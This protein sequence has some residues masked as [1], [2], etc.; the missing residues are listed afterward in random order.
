MKPALLLTALFGL[1]EAAANAKVGRVEILERAD[2]AGGQ[3]FGLA[4][5]YEKLVGRVHFKVRPDD[6]H[7]QHIVDLDKADRDGTGAVAFS[8]DLFILKPKRLERGNGALL[9]EV[10]NRGGKSLLRL[11]QHGSGSPD[12]TTAAQIGDGFLFRQGFTLVWVGWQ[13]DV[14]DEPHALRLEAPVA[15]DSRGSLAGLVRADFVVP[16]PT[17]DAPL[18]HAIVGR[19]GGTGYPV[20]EPASRHNL[21]TVRDTPEGARRVLPRRRWSFARE[22]SGKLTPDTRFVHLEGGFEPGKI[23]EV[24][25]VAREPR[26]VGLG[27]AAIRDLVS[28]LKYDAG[29][30]AKVER[31][32]AIG[33]SQSGRFL[34]H[35]LYQD[36]NADEAGRQVFDGVIAHVAGAGRGSFNHRFAQ[37]SRDGQPMSSLH[38]PTDLFPFADRPLTDPLGGATS[39]LLDAARASKTVPKL[40]YVNT[41]Y[42]YWSR[43]AS[44]IHTTPD[45]KADCEPADETRIYFLAGLQH[46]SGPFPPAHSN[47]P[48]LRGQQKQ[49]PNPVTWIWR[50]LVTD[51]VKW[52]EQGAAPPPSNPPRLADG[53]LVPLA[54][55]AFPRLPEIRVPVTVHAAYGLDFGRSFAAGVITKEPPAV[56][57][58]FPVFVP[59]VDSDGNDRGGVRIPELAVPLATYTGWNLRDPS[60]GAPEQRV[61]FIG[62]YIPFARTAEE[63]RRTGDPRPSIGE[64]YASREQYLG[65]YAEAATKVVEAGFLLPEDLGAVLSRGQAEWKEATR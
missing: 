18:G 19:I 25:Y 7:N 31:A 62:S 28:H 9:L 56:G 36:F 39:G 60:I 55:L 8:A 29:A 15:R 12:P 14:P 41:S 3:S 2:V 24:V 58:P 45:G 43:A 21:L 57:R 33:I 32:Y 27:L 20:A 23:Y 4:G 61:S 38:Y 54:A 11:L 64:R 5:A 35:F 52:V 65:L 51:M 26:V 17:S 50:A 53:T 59:Q 30:P 10:P 48:D 6:H 1:L 16:R 34:R 47:V 44:L 40:F 37:P 46:F 42:E 49:N 22:V 63:R 13:F